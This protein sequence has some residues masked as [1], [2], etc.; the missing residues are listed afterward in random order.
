MCNQNKNPCSNGM[1]IEFLK[2][3]IIFSHIGS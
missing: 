3:L 2:E 1:K